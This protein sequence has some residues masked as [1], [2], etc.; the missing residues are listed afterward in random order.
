MQLLR[1]L[2]AIIYTADIAKAQKKVSQLCTPK[3][4]KNR[5]IK[6]Q[7][8]QRKKPKYNNFDS[9]FCSQNL[10]ASTIIK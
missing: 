2:M 7:R 3:H 6:K 4:W 9:T 5:E 10:N 1:C 8:K